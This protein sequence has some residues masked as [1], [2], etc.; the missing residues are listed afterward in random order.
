MQVKT[1]GLQVITLTE[2]SLLVS[3]N[4]WFIYFYNFIFIATMLSK[5]VFLFFV[6]NL[7]ALIIIDWPSKSW[8]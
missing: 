5:Y 8:W 6:N 4:V 1:Y 7:I 2:K 3:N